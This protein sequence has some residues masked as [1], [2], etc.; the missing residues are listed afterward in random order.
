[1]RKMPE[2]YSF[3]QVEQMLSHKIVGEEI[4]TKEEL[5]RDF[6]DLTPK[7]VVDYMMEAQK[8]ILSLTAYINHL[9]EGM[10]DA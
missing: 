8:V 6:L 5:L 7:K 10:S 2:L 3:T 1:M 9:K 4:F